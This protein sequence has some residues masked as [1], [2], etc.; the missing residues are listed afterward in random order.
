MGDGTT[1]SVWT[2]PGGEAG[3]LLETPNRALEKASTAYVSPQ[4]AGVFHR[5]RAFVHVRAEFRAREV[6]R[7]AE[8][9]VARKGHDDAGSGRVGV[10]RQNGRTLLISVE[11]TAVNRRR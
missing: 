10:G 3:G 1:G 9:R 5:I 2:S 11:W 8:L 6:E 7:Q 4:Q